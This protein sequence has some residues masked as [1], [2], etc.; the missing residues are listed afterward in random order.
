MEKDAIETLLFMSS[1]GNS[2]YSN[3]RQYP[4]SSPYPSAEQTQQNLSQLPRTPLRTQFMPS[5]KRVGFALGDVNGAANGAG[6]SNRKSPTLLDR[7]NLRDE[8][9]ID[10][11]LDQMGSEE[12]S[13]SDEDRLLERRRG[14]V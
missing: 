14:V 9:S 12:S 3:T 1:P 10:R 11:V 8:A 2:Q 4:M 7:V 13:S 5:E 6:A